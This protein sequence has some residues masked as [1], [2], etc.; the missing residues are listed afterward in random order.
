[1]SAAAVSATRADLAA[2]YETARVRWQIANRA[3]RTHADRCWRLAAGQRCGTCLDLEAAQNRAAERVH[4]L[5]TAV[6]EPPTA[7]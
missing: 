2:A 1:M 3:E 7:T 5:R 6:A 4:E